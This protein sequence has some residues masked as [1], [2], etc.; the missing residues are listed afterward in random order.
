MKKMKALLLAIL[1]LAGV[2][3]LAACGGEGGTLGGAA[4]GYQVKVVDALGN[5]YGSG[6]IVRFMQNGQQ[7][8]M[9]KV[10]E[11]GVAVKDLPD[12]D[13]TVELQFTDSNAAYYYDKTDLTLSAGQK[14]LEVK[15]SYALSGEGMPLF[16]GGKDVTAHSVDVGCTYVKLTPGERTYVLFTPTEAGKYEFAAAGDAAVGY[17][18]APHFVQDQNV[19]EEIKDNKSYTNIKS[20][21]IGSGETGT[22]VLVLGIDGA[23]GQ[24]SEILTIQRVGEPDWDVSDEPWQPYLTSIT[25]ESYKLPA[26]TELADFDLTAPT[27]E[28]PL[29][30]GADNFYHLDAA[31]GPLVLV[32]LGKKAQGMKYTDPYEAVLENVDVGKIFYDEAGTFVKKELYSNCLRDYLNVMDPD[33]GVYPLTQDLMYIIQQAGEANGWYDPEKPGFYLFEDAQGNEMPGINKDIA[34]LFMCCY[35]AK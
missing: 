22:A 5:P 26:G 29:V 17:Y 23:E 7:V 10:D 19:A 33:A 21:M 30:L 16:A 14:S 31:D 35:I 1:V 18:G 13:Y 2:C 11:N 9:Q 27:D 12:G 24:T 34:W 25:L 15:L 20:H 4:D 28:Y 3:L 6:I 8:S 32:R